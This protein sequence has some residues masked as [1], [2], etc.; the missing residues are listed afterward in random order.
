[1]RGPS[2]DPIM[3]VDHAWGAPRRQPS[4]ALKL[5]PGAAFFTASAVEMAQF[6]VPQKPDRLLPWLTVALLCCCGADLQRMRRLFVEW[7]PL[8]GLIFAYDLARASVGR[9]WA[10]AHVVPQ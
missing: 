8:V 7:L 9:F 1:M 10:H 4:L 5:A 6:G 2:V 3:V